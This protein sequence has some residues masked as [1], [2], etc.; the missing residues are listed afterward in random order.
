MVNDTIIIAIIVATLHIM[1]FCTFLSPLRA[2]RICSCANNVMVSGL[3]NV[4]NYED[5]SVHRPF[6]NKCKTKSESVKV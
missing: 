5:T 6:M 3:R 2:A 4:A 1:I